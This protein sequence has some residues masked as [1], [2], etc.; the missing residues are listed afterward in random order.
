MQVI[1]HAFPDHSRLTE[2]DAVKYGNLSIER[3]WYVP[4]EVAI[5]QPQDWLDELQT[6]LSAIT[7]Q[8]KA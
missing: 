3:C 6:R 1:E 5:D 4:V 8:D 7:P 2:K